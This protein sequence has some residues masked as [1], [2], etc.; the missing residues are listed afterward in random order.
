MEEHCSNHLL[1]E[2]NQ[3][4]FFYSAVCTVH[5]ERVSLKNI[6]AHQDSIK[7]LIFVQ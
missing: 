4:S 1:T 3:N 2:V 6:S 7:L 5:H